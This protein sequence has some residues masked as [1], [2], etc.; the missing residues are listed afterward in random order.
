MIKK[1][2]T[3]TILAVLCASTIMQAATAK[4][5]AILEQKIIAQLKTKDSSLVE[6]FKEA[7]I[8]YDSN[9]F[10]KADSLYTIVYNKVP[11][12]DHVLRRLGSTHC[13]LGKYE[14]G[15]KL[16]EQALSLNRSAFNLL[17]LAYY[18]M[19][20]YNDSN[21]PI[22]NYDKALALL[23]EGQR[24]P[25]GKTCDFPVLIAQ[26]ALQQ[27]Q[28]GPFRTATNTLLENYPNELATHYYAAILNTMDEN[29]M[30]AEKEILLAKDLGLEDKVV[31]DFLDSGVRSHVSTHRWLNNFLWVTVFWACGLLFLFIL[32]KLLSTL[33]L[34]SFERQIKSNTP[35]KINNLIKLIYRMLINISG[36]YYYLSLPIILI[37]VVA[38]VV[39][40]FYLFFMIGRIPVQLML[41]LVIGSGVS[42]YSMIRSLLI[43]TQY[44]D[45]GRALKRDE[46]PALYALAEEVARA[47]DTRPID[48][49]RITATTDLAVYEK[50]SW[51]QK[52]NDKAQRILILGVGVLK[53]FKQSDFRAVLAHEYGHF[54]HRDTAG[55]D[56]AL[57]VRNDMSK[58]FYSLY[59]AG[60]TVWW[61]IA[62][63]FLRL[64]HFIFRRISHGATRLQEV[65]ADRV[66]AQVYG[67]QAFQNGLTHVIRR[68]IEFT[69]YANSEIETAKTNKRALNNLYALTGNQDESIDK[70]LNK[71]LNQKT[72][73]D[74]THP[75]PTDRFRYISALPAKYISD[76]GAFVTALFKNW[77]Q[78]T[79]EMTTFIEERVNK[80]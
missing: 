1:L 56:V 46:A 72:S 22:P 48:E 41:I 63:Q 55:G 35:G 32:G 37:L 20:P 6:V 69:T 65:L 78:L 19:S 29:W 44:S 45:P 10:K 80:G 57:R 53:D 28:L 52:L 2:I 31:Q 27:K 58:Y 7:T 43:K 70:E 62:F 16:L 68:E 77:D 34:A 74:D 47:L 71:V 14:D 15:S 54:S 59:A 33:T 38:L 4:R 67:V 36:V 17:A 42:I 12:F 49:I 64:Y 9:D 21:A 66:A 73:E 18:Y 75:S 25:D 76:E 3:A 23:Q 24:L 60:Q 40:L 11:T 51:K 30:D 79:L 39:A 26:I 13:L 50:G 61:N 5:D 8:A